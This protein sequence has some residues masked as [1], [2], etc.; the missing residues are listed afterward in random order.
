MTEAPTAE[1]ATDEERVMQ[2]GMAA[3]KQL[4]RER[5]AEVAAPEYEFPQAMTRSHWIVAC[6]LT[7]IWLVMMYTG[8]WW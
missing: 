5:C 8:Y 7:V 3:F 2:P 1:A 6:V 4:A